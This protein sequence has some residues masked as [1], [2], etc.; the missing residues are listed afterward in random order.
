MPVVA[1]MLLGLVALK[2]RRP[3]LAGSGPGCGLVAQVHR[4]A[5]GPVGPVGGVVTPGTAGPWAL[6]AGRAR[7]DGPGGP[8]RG[9]PQP[10]GLRG[11]RDPVPPGPGRGV[12]A[13]GQRPA[14]AHPGGGASRDPPGLRGRRGRGRGRGPGLATVETATSERRRGGRPDR[15]GDADRHPA[16][17][18]HP[19]G[20][21]ALPDQPVRLGLDARPGRRSG[22]HRRRDGADQL[23]SGSS[24]SS[25]ENVVVPAEVVGDTVAPTSQ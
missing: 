24:N 6:R 19:G 13:G 2:R 15:V 18:G 12:V 23:S 8:A 14:G 3:L 16:G 17:P 22:R 21:P 1:L 4:L 7:G 11:Q 25:S 9:P 5:P 10:V 20:L